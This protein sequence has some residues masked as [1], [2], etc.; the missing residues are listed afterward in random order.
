MSLKFEQHIVH[1]LLFLGNG[2]VLNVLPK[3]VRLS[4]GTVSDILDSE[5]DSWN[6]ALDV[7]QPPTSEDSSRWT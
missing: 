7:R 2:D 1:S 5:V 3:N 6:N 4:E